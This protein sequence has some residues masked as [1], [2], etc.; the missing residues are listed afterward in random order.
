MPLGKSEGK[1]ADVAG[2]LRRA[3]EFQKNA[4]RAIGGSQFG[5]AA[6]F[7][8]EGAASL[9]E[10]IHQLEEL[11][12]AGSK[13]VNEANSYD[14]GYEQLIREYLRAISYE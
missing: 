4:A 13:S 2:E 1:A 12:F 7:G 9:A 14:D 11:V 10:A 6:R 5:E 3:S 8:G